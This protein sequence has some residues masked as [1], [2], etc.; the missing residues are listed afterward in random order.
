MKKFTILALA[1]LLVVALT[2]PAAALESEFGGAWN[3]R[4]QTRSNYSGFDTGTADS[5]QNVAT[6]TR[7]YYTAKINDNLKF[8]NQFEMDAMWGSDNAS[9]DG[10]AATNRGYGQVGADGANIEIRATYADFNTGPVNWTVGVQNYN[11]FRGYYIAEQASGVIGRWRVAEPFVLAASWL[12]VYE[13]N[14]GT[15]G[16]ENEN[17]DVDSYTLSGAFFFSENMSIK[18]SFNWVHSSES[19]QQTGVAV[20]ENVDRYTYGLDFDMMFDNFGVWATAIGQ[21]GTQDVFGASDIDFGGYLFALG[22]NVM[23]GAVEIYAEGAYASGDDD[24]IA[25]G[26][27]DSFQAPF[28]SHGWAELLADGDLWA[29]DV[30][31]AGRPGVNDSYDQVTDLIYIGGGVKF[32][33]MEKLTINPSVWYAMLDEDNATG[34]DE[35]GTE[36]DLKIT[37][38]LV[39][40]L[41]LDLIGAYLFAGDAFSN[42][43]VDND[44]DAYEY[45]MILSLSF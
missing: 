14:L 1:A 24:G 16:F 42:T 29:E 9:R 5:E 12:K 35:L 21:S 13:S 26:D 11:L 7:L 25:D 15:T 19:A 3:T 34:D 27:L 22:G 4:F 33:P 32:S 8:V 6:R 10:E 31:P 17:G 40:G 41:N 30:V 28:A 37:Y 18:P 38:Q 45:G 43:A 2:V 36:V 39:E 20:F 44:D 23:L